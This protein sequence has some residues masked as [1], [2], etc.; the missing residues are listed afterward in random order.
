MEQTRL[1]RVPLHY[2]WK[3]LM[4][5]DLQHHLFHLTF[6]GKLALAPIENPHM[7]LDMGTGTGIWA[8]DYGNPPHLP[9]KF[10]SK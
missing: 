4:M 6:D 9:F 3:L 7:V 2:Q 8:M 5:K 1:G 10:P